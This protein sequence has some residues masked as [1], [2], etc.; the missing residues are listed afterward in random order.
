MTTEGDVL[1]DMELLYYSFPSHYPWYARFQ[2]IA[3]LPCTTGRVGACACA[4]CCARR[5]MN[6][7]IEE[8]RSER[9]EAAK[10]VH[11]CGQDSTTLAGLR[12]LKKIV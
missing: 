8:E 6:N 11:P 7:A 1:D 9:L 12:S 5:G 2:G 4:T 10:G 3:E